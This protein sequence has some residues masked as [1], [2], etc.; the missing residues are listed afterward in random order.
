MGVKLNLPPLVVGVVLLLVT[1]V[2]FASAPSI[3][4]SIY[5][6][7]SVTLKLSHAT[8]LSQPLGVGEVVVMFNTTSSS[9]FTLKLHGSVN[10]GGQDRPFIE[11]YLASKR[12]PCREVC[13]SFTNL[14]LV[15]VSDD[16]SLE[17]SS[18]EPLIITLNTTSLQ[19]AIEG[20]LRLRGEGVYRDFVLK[21]DQQL[22]VDAF[23][24]LGLVGWSLT[25][26]NITTRQE[27]QHVF[28]EF[29]LEFD[30]ARSLGGL[31]L[32]RESIKSIVEE[33]VEARVQVD[34]HLLSSSSR[35]VFNITIN[36]SMDI[37][38][39]LE[40]A[41][42]AYTIMSTFIG[43]I[44]VPYTI[45]QILGA[46]VNTTHIYELLK[47][48]T[49]RFNV[50]GPSGYLH[51]SL[52]RDVLRVELQ[53]PRVRG[54]NATTPRDTLVAIYEYVEQL[55]FALGRRE[56]LDVRVKLDL[57]PGLVALLNGA[58]V[59]EISFRDLSKL[60]I[61]KREAVERQPSLDLRVILVITLASLVVLTSILVLKRL[62][63]RATTK[64]SILRPLSGV[65][66][67]S[68]VVCLVCG[69][70]PFIES[71]NAT[72]ADQAIWDYRPGASTVGFE[73]WQ[74]HPGYIPL[75]EP[76][77]VSVFINALSNDISAPDYPMIVNEAKTRL[78]CGEFSKILARVEVSVESVVPGRPGVNYDRPLWVFVEGTPLVVGTTAQR[79]RYVAMSDVTHLYPM[80]TC[81]VREFTMLM[82]NWIMPERGLTGY[83]KVNV[84]LL[85][86]PGRK[87]SWVPD[88]VIPLW[89]SGRDWV[90][91]S[92][93]R[94][95]L[96]W[97]VSIPSNA[98]QAILY[99]YLEGAS[100]EEFWWMREPP[101]RLVYV[102]DDENKTIA[103]TQPFPFIYTGGLI[104]HLWHPIPSINTYI[105]HPIV[106]DV[107]PYLYQLTKARSL[108]ITMSDIDDYWFIGGFIA[109]KTTTGEVKYEFLGDDVYVEIREENATVDNTPTRIFIAQ[110]TNTAGVRIVTNEASYV[111][112]V[113]YNVSL[114]SHIKQRAG[115]LET[116]ITQRWSY[117]SSWLNQTMRYEATS[118]FTVNKS[119]L[120]EPEGPLHSASPEAPVPAR[121]KVEVL[122]DHRFDVFIDS[123]LTSTKHT[124]FVEV[125]EAKGVMGLYVYY[126]SPTAYT[127]RHISY[128]DAETTKTS[129]YSKKT[130]VSL[131]TIPEYYYYR[132]TK[133]TATYPPIKS[134]IV[135]DE[136]AIYYVENTIDLVKTALYIT[137]L[138]D[139]ARLEIL[140]GIKP[141]ESQPIFQHA[142]HT[143]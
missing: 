103:V 118:D 112:H 131:L 111:Y 120:V 130:V 142:T 89:S 109:L 5:S 28:L 36:S 129:T 57:E 125:V 63:S 1:I 138:T 44:P 56:I 60:E 40:I 58:E 17:A 33:Y 72:P 11:L 87:P 86:Y 30:V 92:R 38:R 9:G 25:L 2:A 124:R 81:S 99:L 66:L 75:V 64:T 91:I 94:P 65:V 48:F 27:G 140:L 114:W 34:L 43:E 80:L 13:R 100:R 119:E 82:R 50:I 93:S 126:T 52:D 49:E 108:A 135:E 20:R 62:K 88:L 83:F 113:V 117:R 35:Q 96:W 69:A 31:E 128:A 39:Y 70:P 68:I 51:I 12:E 97:N 79:S 42:K 73:S 26:K 54:K 10:W 136:L 104:P 116:K 32:L 41:S 84:T 77:V 3:H 23:K 55:S 139:L 143:P 95:I 106:I 21:L 47:L 122:V 107:T 101:V 29:T 7:A 15:V 105:F 71:I 18:T 98:T 110:Y 85:Y 14:N 133:A 19:G 37:N 141:F 24:Q 132:R 59:S 78:P 123:E 46:L 53:T 61:A 127:V 67:A 134:N 8:R 6:D 115:S 74:N 121:L 90:T 76:V 102:L 4:I 22:L 137:L 16:G 45:N